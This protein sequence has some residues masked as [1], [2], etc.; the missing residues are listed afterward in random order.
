MKALYNYIK[1]IVIGI[2]QLMQGMYI[3]MLNM[4]RP[5]VTE[6]YPEN[7]G[8]KQYGEWFRAMLVMPHDV[9]NHHRCTACGICMNSCPNGTIKVESNMIKDETTG[10]DKRVLNRYLYDLGS[11]TFCA[12]CTQNCPFHAI[13]WS[14][15]FENTVFNC[16]K[17]VLKLNKEGSSLMVKKTENKE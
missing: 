15:D 12:L 3:S 2:Y 14:N 10:K 9:E 5:K 8:K 13:E 6:Q 17:L 11:C 1:N 7:R 4:L 16:Q